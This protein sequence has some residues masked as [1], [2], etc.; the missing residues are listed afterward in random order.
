[1]NEFWI[2]PVVW[3][4]V[5][6]TTLALCTWFPIKIKDD[7]IRRIVYWLVLVPASLVILFYGYPVGMEVFRRLALSF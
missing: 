4:G 3:L 7:R 6:L 2:H 5:M 1:M